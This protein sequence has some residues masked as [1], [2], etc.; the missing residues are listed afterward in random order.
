MKLTS[1]TVFE[2]K[3]KKGWIKK[4]TGSDPVYTWAGTFIKSYDRDFVL[5]KLTEEIKIN[6]KE[7]KTYVIEFEIKEPGVYQLYNIDDACVQ[8][9][10]IYAYIDP[11]LKWKD[12]NGDENIGFAEKIY[13]KNIKGILDAINNNK[14]IDFENLNK[15]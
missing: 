2:T 13:A 15:Y 3:D 14:I 12:E 5:R 10:K 11:N 4:I 9:D 6:S 1:T 8:Y 7:R